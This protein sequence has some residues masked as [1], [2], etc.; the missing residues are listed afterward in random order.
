[1]IYFHQLDDRTGIG[2]EPAFYKIA[3]LIIASD[4]SFPDLE[5]YIFEN[6]QGH[7]YSDRSIPDDNLLDFSS[8]EIIYHGLG[9][10]GNENREIIHQKTDAARLITISG[11]GKFIISKDGNHIWIVELSPRAT[12]EL[13]L[14]AFLGPALIIALAS[15]GIMCLHASAIL[16]GQKAIAFLGESGRGKSTLAWYLGKSLS[17]ATHQIGDDILP[18]AIENRQ[19]IVFPHFPQRKLS[20]E[21]QPINF[22]EEQVQLA[23]AYI[24][25]QTT[26]LSPEFKIT[27][28]NQQS[29]SLALL[30]HTVG[31]RLFDRELLT[32]HLIFST[33]VAEICRCCSFTYPHNFKLQPV[34]ELLLEDLGKYL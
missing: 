15:R 20:K 31:A 17:I 25:N 22:V 28:L 13:T 9:W 33:Q 2:G 18:V 8:A 11:I 1:M 14:D 21:E 3:G 30:R 24:L 23:G 19:V 32:E 34:Q 6:K 27:L 4:L 10:I 12:P 5:P 26:Q 16:I 29:A 7:G